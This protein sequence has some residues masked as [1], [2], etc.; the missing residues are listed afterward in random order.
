MVISGSG[1]EATPTGCSQ[2][3]T[4]GVDERYIESVVN[5]SCFCRNMSL[6]NISL[7]N[8]LMALKV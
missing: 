3:K 6:L 4:K 8:K 2:M 1:L 7:T 5:T